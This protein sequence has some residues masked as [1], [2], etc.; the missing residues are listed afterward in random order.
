M[1][2]AYIAPQAIPSQAANS[3]HMMKMAQALA[4]GGHDVTLFAARGSDD[5][6]DDIFA[7]YGVQRNFKLK[8]QNRRPGKWGLIAYGF[9]NAAGARQM[10]V[11]LV[12]SRCLMSGWAAAISNFP[13]L[14]ETHDSPSALNNIARSIFRRLTEHKNLRGLVVISVALKNHIAAQ[15]KIPAEKIIVAPDGAD[16]MPPA[17]S[18]PFEKNPGSFHA[19]YTGHLYSGRGIEII[20][21]MAK[22]CGDVTF[23]IVGGAPGDLAY[24]QD[25]LKSL[26]NIVFYGHIAPG[27][28]PGFLQNF[29]VL[30]APYQKKVAVAGNT[31]D[32]AAWMSPLKIFEYMAAGKPMICSD[33]PVLREVLQNGENAVLVSPDSVADWTAALKKLQADQSLAARIG[34]TA[35]EK[36]LSHYRWQKRAEKIMKAV[37]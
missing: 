8:L 12:F 36:F 32:T 26:K 30:L 4:Y 6:E 14:F 17:Q 5:C 10:K 21:E 11:D 18:A 20:A 37:G 24:W 2:I 31:G 15:N 22:A 28:V 35:Q 9:K 27:R 29:D 13:V 33:M 7:Y 1:K 16:P 34:K 23:H 3:I 19:G 25:R